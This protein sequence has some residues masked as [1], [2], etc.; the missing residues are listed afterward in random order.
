MAAGVADTEEG[1]ALHKKYE[2]ARYG[3][4]F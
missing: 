4:I 2:Q 1:K 3:N